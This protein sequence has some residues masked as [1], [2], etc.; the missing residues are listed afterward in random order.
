MS[1]VFSLMPR[2]NRLYDVLQILKR[3]GRVVLDVPESG[4]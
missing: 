1:D 2:Q 3:I 4:D